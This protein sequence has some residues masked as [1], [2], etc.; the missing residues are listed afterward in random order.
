MNTYLKTQR[1][2]HWALW[3]QHRVGVRRPT[4]AGEQ[5]WEGQGG[6][7]SAVCVRSPPG[8]GAGEHHN[9]DLCTP[10]PPGS[11]IRTF[12]RFAFSPRLP[13]GGG[14]LHGRVPWSGGSNQIFHPKETPWTKH[15][16]T[17]HH[18][19]RSEAKALGCCHVI[20]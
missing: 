5:H 17:K 1:W 16:P 11:G 2:G 15:P 3:R 20:E 13:P 9:L 4:A 10:R 14:S 19:W 6:P 8:Q 7:P 12:P 18:W